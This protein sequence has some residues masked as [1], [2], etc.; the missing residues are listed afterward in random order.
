MTADPT[1][2]ADALLDQA[3]RLHL[4]EPNH[5]LEQSA[6]IAAT[7]VIRQRNRLTNQIHSQR[8]LD[9]CDCQLVARIYVWKP[10]KESKVL[11]RL[12]WIDRG[13]GCS[14][15]V[16]AAATVDPVDDLS[17]LGR[18]LRRYQ[19]LGQLNDAL[20]SFQLEVV[21]RDVDRDSYSCR[22]QH[23]NCR[24]GSNAS[25]RTRPHNYHRGKRCNVR[26]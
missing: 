7:V 2:S 1:R 10:R 19:F 23:S 21:A 16:R 4:R 11:R 8:T 20:H 26:S 9:P 14:L 15:G 18:T 6:F 3:K 25:R 5:V 12:Y 17:N 13:P 24:S 22:R